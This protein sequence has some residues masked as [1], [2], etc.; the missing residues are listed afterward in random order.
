[1]SAV[2]FQTYLSLQTINNLY[3]LQQL[4]FSLLCSFIYFI[5]AY[6]LTRNIYYNVVI[7][8]PLYYKPTWKIIANEL[9][10]LF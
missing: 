5:K 7:I 1:M 3:V 4:I 6:N 10:T 9:D 2:T 8:I